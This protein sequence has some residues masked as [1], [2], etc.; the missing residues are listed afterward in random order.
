MRSIKRRML[1]DQTSMNSMYALDSRNG[2]Q[3]RAVRNDYKSIPHE[4]P[5]FVNNPFYQHF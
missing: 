3:P 1:R 4:L 2:P 5:A